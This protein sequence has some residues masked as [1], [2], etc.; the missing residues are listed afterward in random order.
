MDKQ[1]SKHNRSLTAVLLIM[2]MVFSAG[3]SH[4]PAKPTEST[5]DT[6][7]N[8]K[9]A[10]GVTTVPATEDTSETTDASLNSLR[11]AMTGTSQL[12]AVAYLGYP[13]LIDLDVQPDPFSLMRENAP[14]LCEDLPFLLE[15]PRERIL[16]NT[17]ELYCIVP[18]DEDASVAVNKG[19]QNDS[20]GEFQYEDVVY[21]SESGAPILLFCNSGWEPDTEVVI[22]DS[23]GNVTQWYPQLDDNQCVMPL[24]N[25]DWENLFFDFTPY[26]EFLQTKHS[27]LKAED[28][29][30][31]TAESLAGSRWVW[32]GYLKDGREVSYQLF[33]EEDLLSVIWNDGI[34]EADHE[35]L[36]TDWELTQEDGFGVLTINF[37]EFAGIRRYNLLYHEFYDELYV[38]MDTLQEDLPI[39]EEPLRRFLSKPYAP[40]PVEMVGVW[41]LAWT[42]I[43]GDRNEAKPGECT[44]EIL[45]SASAGLMMSYTSRDFP[46]KNFEYELLIMDER[47]MYFG[48]GNHAWV[49]DLDYVGPWDTTYTVTLSAEDIL[50]KQNYFLVDGAPTVS[51]EYFC[52]VVE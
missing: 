46:N 3:C 25:D 2:L 20:T 39:G 1:R 42:E 17:G 34:D 9:P 40:E 27:K 8:T 38:A 36:Y 26:R 11:Q 48:C 7:Q 51:Y 37:G 19:V 22:T 21:R 45:S 18:R 28:W 33:F 5:L 35:Y 10:T 14:S 49:A 43:E 13:E 29:S 44:I 6:T 23:Q 52:R 31:P 30:A 32:Y 15:I 24:R 16:G 41:E 47:E 12:F 50:I 4:Q